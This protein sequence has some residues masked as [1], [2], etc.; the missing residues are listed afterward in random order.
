MQFW[1][2]ILVIKNKCSGASK[3]G[4]TAFSN[5]FLGDIPKLKL[6]CALFMEFNLLEQNM[7]KFF[8]SMLFYPHWKLKNSDARLRKITVQKCQVYSPIKRFYFIFNFCLFRYFL[9]SFLIKE[10]QCSHF[11]FKEINVFSLLHFV[12]Q[13]R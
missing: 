6:F 11:N 7:P 2:G 10:P 13:K 12:Q 3:Y 1:K 9:L 8:K 4:S 5:I